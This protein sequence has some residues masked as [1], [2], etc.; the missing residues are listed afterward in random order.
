ME[1]NSPN[2]KKTFIY[3]ALALIGIIALVAVVFIVVI[4]TIKPSKLPA[5]ISSSFGASQ[6]VEKVK[7]LGEV[8]E[9]LKIVPKGIVEMDHEDEATDSYVVHVYEIKD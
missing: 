5:T 3:L 7:S 4:K 1:N 2:T 8:Q 6:A 9:F